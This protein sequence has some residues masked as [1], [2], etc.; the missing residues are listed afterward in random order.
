VQWQRELSEREKSRLEF[1][2]GKI[3]EKI[4]NSIGHLENYGRYCLK[5]DLYFAAL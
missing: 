4:E 2:I 5:A 1:S 3:T